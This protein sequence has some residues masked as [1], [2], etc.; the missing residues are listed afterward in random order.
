MAIFLDAF[1]KF[2]INSRNNVNPTYLLNSYCVKSI[3]LISVENAK[4]NIL[5]P[6]D[7]CN[8]TRK[9]NTIYHV[10][11]CLGGDKSSVSNVL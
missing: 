6:R 5:C 7:T 3:M 4:L 2:P 8:L 10:Q 11:S 9:I 1:V